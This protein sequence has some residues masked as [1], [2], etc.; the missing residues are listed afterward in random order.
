[1]TN[2]PTPAM[3]MPLSASAMAVFRP[4]SV[5]RFAR[6]RFFSGTC[7]FMPVA[8]L[9]PISHA[10]INIRP[11]I[12]NVTIADRIGSP[13]K[14]FIPSHVVQPD[15]RDSTMPVVPSRPSCQLRRKTLSMIRPS[16]PKNGRANMNAI[17]SEI[18]P[19]SSGS[20]SGVIPRLASS[21]CTYSTIG[22]RGSRPIQRAC[23]LVPGR[24]NL[25]DI[26][27]IVPAGR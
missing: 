22:I 10:T 7:W 4:P 2:T 6:E 23:R 13:V 25:R 21:D 5:D 19:M 9:S 18:A 1:M 3:A 17:A 20:R 27:P 14:F 12:P 8:K 16:R 24:G 11:W 15:A 26:C